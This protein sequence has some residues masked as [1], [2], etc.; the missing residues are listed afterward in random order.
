MINDLDM[1][2]NDLD[3][4]VIHNNK[5]KR[6]MRNENYP[7]EGPADYMGNPRRYRVLKKAPKK[8]LS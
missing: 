1:R 4:G 2:L 3:M 6:N 8:Q 7:P 5:E